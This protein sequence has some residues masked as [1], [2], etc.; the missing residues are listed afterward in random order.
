MSRPDE[1]RQQTRLVLESG[2][3]R[4]AIS[5]LGAEPQDW[6]VAGNSLLWPGDS[7][8][9]PQQSPILFPVVGWTRNAEMLIKGKRYPLGLHGFASRQAFAVIRRSPE[10][11]TLR[12]SDN[13]TTRALYPFA[14][15]LEVT[16]TLSPTTFTA[17]FTVENP[18]AEPM[19]YALGLH[20]GFVFPLAGGSHQGHEVVFDERVSPNVPRIAPGGLIA[21]S[22]RRIPLEGGRLRLSPELFS[23]DALCFFDAAST[24]L[25]YVNGRGQEVAVSV[26]DFP[27]IALWTKPGA[28]FLCIECWTGYS[29]PED[30]DGEIF[31][32]PS[33]R[34]LG[35]GASAQHGVTYVWRSDS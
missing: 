14:F 27:H 32:K 22:S 10:S 30:F 7:A 21:R 13:A 34:L 35:A 31:E 25:F 19:P 28:P 23:N 16:Y 12:L 3:A 33:M 26:E 29:D 11:V 9:W 8:W 17:R 18:G 20:P 15:A 24:D 1:S 2:S 5:T 4:A 6:R